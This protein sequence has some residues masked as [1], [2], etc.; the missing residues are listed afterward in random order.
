MPR[1]PA[2]IE[3]EEW[4]GKHRDSI[5]KEINPF[6]ERVRRKSNS[7]NSVDSKVGAILN[8]CSWQRRL[9]SEIIAGIKSGKTVCQQ[10]TSLAV[11]A[12]GIIAT[13]R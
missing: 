3:S 4:R 5:M 10:V 6:L 12:Q 2:D 1:R 13:Q 8:L 9:P 11:K 7:Q